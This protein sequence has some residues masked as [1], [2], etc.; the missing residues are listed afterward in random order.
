MECGVSTACFYPEE[1]LK[2]LAHLGQLNVPFAEIFLNTYRELTPGYANELS[3]ILE[4]QNICITALHPFTSGMETF[5]FATDYPTRIE[6]GYF[7]Y[8][9]YFSFCQMLNIPRFVFHGMAKG[10]SFPL[11]RYAEHY[12]RLREMA[13]DFGV[14]FLHENV[15]RCICSQPENVLRLRQLTHEDIGFVFDIK[16]ARRAEVSP[17]AMLDAMGGHVQHLHLSDFTSN[18]DCTVPGVGME[19]FHAVAKKLRDTNF[20]GTAILEVYRTGFGDA[21]ELAAGLAFL[22]RVF[23]QNQGDE[24]L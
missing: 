8:R 9:Q 2:G 4:K 7:F 19:N 11:E 15:V 24:L 22:N 16:Q 1:T 14:D 23:T 20:N 3:R 13:R 5:F 17:L 10:F 21:H 18:C 12:L 6:D